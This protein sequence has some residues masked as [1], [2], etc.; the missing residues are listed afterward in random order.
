MHVAFHAPLKPP[1]HTVPSG[2]RRMARAL[3]DLLERLGHRVT[4]VSRLRTFDREGDLLRQARLAR[5]GERLAD[6]LAS[7]ALPADGYG[8]WL[9]YHC[10]H[11]APDLLGPVLAA[12]WCVPYLIAEASVAPSRATGPWAA[13][14]RASVKAIAAADVVLALTRRDE[15]CLREVVRP[16]ARLERFPPFL[17][18][19]PFREAARRRAGHRAAL[20]AR[21]G[22]AHELP[23]LLTVAMMREDVKLT[24]YMQLADAL[25]RMPG[26]GWHL[27]VAGTG[28]ARDR[29]ESRLRDACGRRVTILGEV[30]AEEM[31]ALYAAADLLVWP[32]VGEAYG[33]AVLEAQAAGT[34]VVVGAHGGVGEIVAGG[35]TGVLVPPDDPTALAAAA[36]ALLRRPVP[37]LLAGEALAQAVE[38]RHGIDAAGE[39][40]RRALAL[41]RRVRDRRALAHRAA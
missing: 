9:T 41:A 31:P 24:S 15:A 29:V 25:E 21:L 18:T 4:L 38:R 22:I 26:D 30:P 36:S 10:H 35:T 20:A 14:H 3:I 28:P 19:A 37:G 11:K 34:P 1:D 39:R 13:G 5:L 17:D 33:M 6:R 7:R 32:A 2:D 27:V 23:V 12:R 8:C 40:L 16:P